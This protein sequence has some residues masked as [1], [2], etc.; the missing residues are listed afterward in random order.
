MKKAKIEIREIHETDF[1]EIV[2]L[3]RELMGALKYPEERY[4]RIWNDNLKKDHYKGFVAVLNNQI[5]GFI[6]IIYFQDLSHGSVVGQI[7]NLI[8]HSEHRGKGIGKALLKRTITLA[9]KHKFI[10]LHIWTEFDNEKAISLYEKMGFEKRSLL[11][12][13]EIE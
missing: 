4:L 8:V 1:K 6:D 12:E 5:V 13:L 9:K 7:Q 3:I 11:L 2:P 10:E